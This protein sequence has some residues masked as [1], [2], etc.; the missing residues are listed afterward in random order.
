MSID[1]TQPDRAADPRSS[2]LVALSVA[3]QIVAGAPVIPQSI[4]ANRYDGGLEL[5]L[6]SPADVAVFARW[7]GVHVT[8]TRTTTKYPF[9]T[10]AAGTW[11]GVGFRAWVMH[12]D[13]SWVQRQQDQA[14][15]LVNQAHD[16]YDLDADS[17]AVVPGCV[18]VGYVTASADSEGVEVAS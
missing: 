16:M 11:H 1:S 4:T 2:Y 10:G 9:E 7:I 6:A 3:E 17:A 13:A 12:E 18:R 15:E 8:T 5:H 14:G